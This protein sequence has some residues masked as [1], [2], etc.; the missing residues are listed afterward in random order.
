MDGVTERLGV[1]FRALRTL[2][3]IAMW[4]AL[5]L[6][7][8][9]LTALA[10]NAFD[11]RLSPEAVALLHPPQNRY[12]ADQNL[13]VTLAGFD[14][15]AGQSVISVGQARIADYNERVDTMLG[16]PLL[17]VET[18]TDPTRLK[19]EGSMDCCRPYEASFWESVRANGSQIQRLMGQNQELYQRYLA[20]FDLPGYYETIRPSV[21]APFYF[22]PSQLRNL[23]LAGVSMRLQSGDDAKTQAALENLRQDIDLWHRMLTGEGNLISKMIAVSFL[24]A[25]SLILS[26]MIADPRVAIPQHMDYYLPQ[27]DLMDWNISNAF[28]AEFRVHAYLH[29]QMQALID[30]HWQPPDSMGSSASRL[31]YRVSSPIAGQFYKINATDNLD[32]KVMNELAG[33]AALDP[34]TFSMNQARFKKWAEKNLDFK[35][36]RT[37]YNPIGKMLVAIAAPAYEN[38]PFRPYDAAALQRL[39]R[40]SFEIRRQRI[41]PAAIAG[42]MK[43]HPEWS[44]HPADG[45]AFVWKQTTG[46]IAIQ[47]VAQQSSYRRFSVHI[48]RG[49]D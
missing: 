12:R 49:S 2:R 15:P 1:L 35:S 19:F 46:E 17:G 37:I 26:D 18:P 40:L 31:W 48:W 41:V 21:A 30:N 9:I 32:A 11:E 6:L 44:T 33:L 45:R 16:N 20:L 39:V 4:G 29:R 36:V 7:A 5:A 27:F 38:Y 8:L 22:V 42:F 28:A 10:I 47:P 34:S 3:R 25:D 43:L 24:Q 13:Y 23:F 14:A